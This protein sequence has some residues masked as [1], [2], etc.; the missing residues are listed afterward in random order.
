MYLLRRLLLVIP[1]LWAIITINFFIVQSAPGGPVDSLIATIEYGQ[2]ATSS[3]HRSGYKNNAESRHTAPFDESHYRG[4]QNVDSQFIA[5]MTQRFGFDKPLYQRYLDMLCNYLRFDFG[6]SLFRG[7]S[8][9]TLIKSRLPVSMSLG[10]WSTMLICVISIPL[11]IK[12]AIKNGTTF[13]IWSSTFITISYAVP[14]FLFAVLLILL[15]AS[16][17]GLS[18]FPLRGLVS[19]NF[20]TL[21]CYCKVI[22]YFWHLA[23]PVLAIV[24]S[25]FAS[26]TLLTKN[27]FL[28]EIHKQYVMTAR[29]RGLDEKTILW[30]HVCRNALLPLIAGFP[31]VFTGLFFMGSL[32]VEV[33]FSL[34]G[35]GLLSFEAAVQQ[36]YPVMFGTL[37]IFTLTGLL[38]N[39]I[40]DMLYTLIDPRIDFE[41]LA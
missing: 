4:A 11:G 37:Y 32:P 35:L 39:I 22:D 20:D 15:F 27:A 33:I 10:L 41:Q 38:L 8:V 21:T 13:D 34:D 30:G 19:S 17:N 23:L 16:S 12:K 14:I 24:M 26:L 7:E 1:T 18:W 25:G 9:S 2:D 6:E 29:A 5:E 31:A 36:D 40:S 28:D 3:G